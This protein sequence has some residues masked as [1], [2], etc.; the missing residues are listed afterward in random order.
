M[1]AVY[2]AAI[3]MRTLISPYRVTIPKQILNFKNL[4]IF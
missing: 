1:K 3:Y 4:D 2:V